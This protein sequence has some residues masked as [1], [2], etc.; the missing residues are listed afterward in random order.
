MIVRLKR[1]LF[2]D[3]IYNMCMVRIRF[4]DPSRPIT[5]LV[6]DPVEHTVSEVM[7]YIQWLP[8]WHS[9]SLD[10]TYVVRSWAAIYLDQSEPHT[11]KVSRDHGSGWCESW[12]HHSVYYIVMITAY[13]TNISEMGITWKCWIWDQF[14]NRVPTFGG[15]VAKLRI[16][17]VVGFRRNGFWY[18]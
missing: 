2:Y 4:I 14:R 5:M 10:G 8:L 9:C 18:I 1:L 12:F 6:S 15:N 7:W 16:W 17:G 11:R 13:V 3:C